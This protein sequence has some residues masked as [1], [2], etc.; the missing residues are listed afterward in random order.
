MVNLN[1]GG[2]LFGI[3]HL[4][5]MQL[6]HFIIVGGGP[7]GCAVALHLAKL[8]HCITI[9][10]GRSN[11]P[12]DPTQSYPIGINPRGMHAIEIAGA[13]ATADGIRA[14]SRPIH[15]WDIFVGSRRVASLA[16]GGSTLGTS[17]GHV[18]VYLMDACVAHSQITVHMNH[19]L[20]SMDFATQTLTFTR[21]DDNHQ[22]STVVT[23]D[24]SKARV[25]GADGVYSSVRAAMQ[26]HDP[27]LDVMVSPWVNE[28]RVL[29][30]S[31][32]QMIQGLDPSVH[33]LFRGAHYT[34]AVGLPRHDGAL[35]WIM[36]LT[37]RDS[38]ASASDGH[39]IHATSPTT[40]N[41]AKLK[42][43]VRSI[44]PG[45]EEIVADDEFRD[46]FDRRTYRGAVVRC[47]HFHS[48]NNWVVLVGDAAHS[49]LPATGEG[50]N[51]GL[52]DAVVLADCVAQELQD[53]TAFR[54]FTIRR[55]P[56]IHA[57][58]LYA[59]YLNA[60]PSFLGER[61]ARILFRILENNDKASIAR[62]LFGPIALTRPPYK[63]VVDK[64]QRRRTLW[65]NLARLV[66]YPPAAVVAIAMWPVDCLTAVLSNSSR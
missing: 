20:Y 63:G 57:L 19:T 24:A 3:L 50:I 66:V 35:Q 36:V 40:A 54:S 58:H 12:N 6:H 53:N 45:F 59:T 33:Y 65:L 22:S 56:D 1:T 4:S 32:G 34:A 64:W 16:S 47:S 5:T 62:T 30:A 51:S 48:R 9:Y 2:F 55:R 31:P 60:C 17:R 28:H 14:S 18:N 46:W 49:V 26:C 7:V 42:A 44:A 37:V 52:E 41:V 29:Y 39:L 11:I 43:W 27:A 21:T 10:E 38:E 61:V 23:V 15:A 25:V 8:G 13:P